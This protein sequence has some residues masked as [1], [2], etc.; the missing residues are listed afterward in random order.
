MSKLRPLLLF[1]T[2]P[3]AIKMAP[4]VHECRRRPDAVEPVVCAAGQHRELLE[5]VVEY[6]GLCPDHRLDVMRF[7]QSLAELTSGS[8]LAIDALLAEVKPDCVVVQGDTTTVMAA[9]LAA[10][11]RSVPLAHVEAG[12]RTG[13]LR[14][15]WPEELNRRVVSLSAATHFAPTRRAADALLAEGIPPATVHVTG[16]TVID[17]LLWTVKRERGRAEHW[18][19]KY[20]MLGSRRLVLITGHRRENF[21]A[22]LRAVCGAIAALAERFPDVAFLYPVHLNPNVLGPVRAALSG[23]PNIHLTQPAAYPEF[24]W[25]MQRSTLI[26]TDSGG[27]QEEAPSLRKPVLVT[28]ETTE[29]PEAVEAGAAELVGTSFDAIVSRASLLLADEAEYARRQIAANPYGDGRAA[30]RIV[31]VLER[32]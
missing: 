9:S 26:I 21:G 22:G 2:R 18:K 23:R 25:L 19:A 14:A 13:N 30:R 31:D 5:P 29:R 12:L 28:R 16:N 4:V 3:E 27:V 24:V 32:M 11:Y 10:F 6:F 7:G 8:L 20:A 1:G 17:A 15:P